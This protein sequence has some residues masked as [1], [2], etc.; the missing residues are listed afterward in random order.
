MKI[1]DKA[2]CLWLMPTVPDTQEVEIRKI[3]GSKP[4]WANSSE[5]LCRKKSITKKG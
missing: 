1:T 4:A 2:R 3:T 5:T